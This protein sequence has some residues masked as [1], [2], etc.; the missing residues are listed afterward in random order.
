MRNVIR[1]IRLSTAQ[2]RKLPD[3]IIIGAQKSG[4]SSLYW[5]LYQHPQ[6]SMSFDKETKFFDRHYSKGIAWYRHQFPLTSTKNK[7][8]GDNTPYYVFHPL[9][10]ERVHKAC[11]DTRFIAIL[12]NPIDRAYSQ[13]Q[14][15]RR[16]GRELNATFEGAIKG[17]LERIKLA[18][19][20]VNNNPLENNHIHENTSYLSRGLYIDQIEDW[21]KWFDLKQLLVLE[22]ESLFKE[23]ET[24]L[25][26]VYDFL[27]VSNVI[28]NDLTPYNVVSYASM[29]PELRE[30]LSGF[31]APYNKRLER[32][33]GMKFNWK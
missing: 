19:I 7:L 12:R 9:V 15:E 20:E 14:M 4:S 2:W 16:K 32:L 3:F 21:L 11:P 18:R 28:A 24:G 23:P 5:W 25:K 6:I 17:E 26:S 1:R 29:D 30:E 22:S 10:P 31:F 33:L 13:Y 27:G 8:A